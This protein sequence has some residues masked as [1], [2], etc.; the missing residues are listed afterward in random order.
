MGGVGCEITD[1][2][3]KDSSCNLGRTKS[4]SSVIANNVFGRTLMCNLEITAL[5]GWMEGPAD[6]TNVLV[7]DNDF[8]A[9]HCPS[10]SIHPGSMAHNVTLHNNTFAPTTWLN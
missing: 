5:Q 6:I 3:F 2:V 4:S 10:N 7:V 9:S 1:N 8:T